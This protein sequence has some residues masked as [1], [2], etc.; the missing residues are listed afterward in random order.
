MNEIL[1]AY[2]YLSQR[3]S[4]Q[5]FLQEAQD[6]R[7]GQTQRGRQGALW[8]ASGSRAQT[9]RAP[10]AGAAASTEVP[11]AEDPP[12]PGR[13]APRSLSYSDCSPGFS[14]APVTDSLHGGETRSSLNRGF[15][16]TQQQKVVSWI[17]TQAL[18]TSFVT[19]HGA[20]ALLAWG[21]A[22][23]RDGVT[24]RGAP[25]PGMRSSWL[26]EAGRGLSRRVLDT[27]WAGHPP[28]WHW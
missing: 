3:F 14:F 15:L 25:T 21:G 28:G 7:G 26:R 13:C 19:L 9:G 17:R 4:V 8:G 12:C 23:L 20:S 1:N 27:L 16:H 2:V 22:R 6:L 11:G 5:V 10:V 24:S 18:T